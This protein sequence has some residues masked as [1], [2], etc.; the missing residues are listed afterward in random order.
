MSE[1]ASSS[2]EESTDPGALG[3][4]WGALIAPERTFSAL[5]ARPR[6][7]AALI[8]LVTLA[9]AFTLVLT[10][11]MDMEKVFREAIEEQGQELSEAQL[12]QQLA[13]AEK[14]AW[15]GVAAQVF[16]QPAVYLVIAAIFLALFRMLGSDIDYRRS[17]AVTVHAF[18]PYAVATLLSIPVVLARD[19][20][21]MDEVQSGSFL[22]SN[23]AAFAPEE[24]GKALLS[25]LGS[26]DLFSFWTLALLALGFRVVARV[27]RGQAWGVTLGLWALYVAG[28]TA[29]AVA[30]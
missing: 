4:L 14:F 19:E 15:V 9:L 29:I 21:S 13:I 3:S 26:I 5:A 24:S 17:L 22:M 12:E 30:F 23:L 27:S 7:V 28:K 25:L 18:M 10:P 8:L 16:F 20:I 6:W 1:P 11:R 2:A